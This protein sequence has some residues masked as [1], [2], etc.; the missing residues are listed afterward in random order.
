LP[1]PSA[2]WSQS[3]DTDYGPGS[4]NVMITPCEN[5]DAFMMVG[6]SV[7]KIMVTSRRQD[8]LGYSSTYLFDIL[9]IRE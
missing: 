3:L 2:K 7:S 4:R 5:R 9:Q 8:D 1:S 6:N